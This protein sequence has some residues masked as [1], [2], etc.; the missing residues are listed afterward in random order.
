MTEGGGGE[1]E[2][3]GVWGGTEAGVVVPQMTKPLFRSAAEAVHDLDHEQ[4]GLLEPAVERR[5]EEFVSIREVVVEAPLR[6][7]Q[8][9]GEGLD[10]NGIDTIGAEHQ[11]GFLDPFVASE[12][13]S[14]NLSRHTVPYGI[15]A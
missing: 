12:W 1:G 10:P 7:T 8:A 3:G 6:H 5:D 14:A 9:L 2:G 13:G 11:E 4:R 15:S